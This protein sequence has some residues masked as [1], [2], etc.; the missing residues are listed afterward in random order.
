MSQCRCSEIRPVDG[1][2]GWPWAASRGAHSR[3]LFSGCAEK[4]AQPRV[5]PILGCRTDDSEL[6]RPSVV[7]TTASSSTESLRA[8][9]ERFDAALERMPPALSA[10]LTAILSRVEAAL[11]APARARGGVTS[12]PASLLLL[13]VSL[14]FEN[15]GTVW[16]HE[17]D[18]FRSWRLV[19]PAAFHR[20]QRALTEAAVLVF[21]PVTLR[22]A[23]S[24]GPD[25]S[26]H[27][28]RSNIKHLREPI[29]SGQRHTLRRPRT[30]PSFPG[31]FLRAG[32]GWLGNLTES[33]GNEGMVQR[34]ASSGSV[35]RARRVGPPG[36]RSRASSL[37]SAS[38]QRSG[39]GGGQARWPCHDQSPY[40]LRL[41]LTHRPHR[42]VNPRAH[43]GSLARAAP[44][45]PMSLAVR[46][47]ALGPPRPQRLFV[48]ALPL[49]GAVH[50]SVEAH[51][52]P[53]GQTW[54]RSGGLTNRHEDRAYPFRDPPPRSCRYAPGDA[55]F[56][57]R[58]ARVRWL[59]S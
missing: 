34:W 20:V 6:T 30:E 2:A 33:R 50:H 4:A 5:A 28:F 38:S 13:N 42:L 27:Y 16:A 11:G 48:H 25:R 57:A 40:L 8:W 41:L 35:P 9:T 14:A 52:L 29:L 44:H 31:H 3:D 54:P 17:V 39:W 1:D 22:L 43:P 21:V 12:S 18:I 46:L 19:D 10:E 7:A 59:W 26:P 55:P 51:H 58:N 37:P 45:V 36:R 56:A 24:V 53:K 47:L 49:A 32:P 23:G 15:V